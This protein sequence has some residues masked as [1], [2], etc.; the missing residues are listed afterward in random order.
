MYVPE[1]RKRLQFL[2]PR[3]EIRNAAGKNLHIAERV[4]GSSLA[5]PTGQV[6]D[7]SRGT[8]LSMAFNGNRSTRYTIDLF[9][10]RRDAYTRV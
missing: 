6:V 9:A 2:S 1:K 8:Y 4:P 10:S 3:S 5:L 7:I